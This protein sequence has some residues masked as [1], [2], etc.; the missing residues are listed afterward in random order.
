M[1]QHEL[2]EEGIDVERG[3]RRLEEIMAADNAAELMQNRPQPRT[4]KQRKDAG[5]PR[6]GKQALVDVDELR[7]LIEERERTRLEFDAAQDVATG[8]YHEYEKANDALNA[9]I[10]AAR[11]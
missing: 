3:Q 8:K 9:Y 10:D 2:I 11:K 5:V 4:R 6:K 1:T 7:K